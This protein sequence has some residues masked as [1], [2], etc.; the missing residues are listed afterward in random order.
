ML[1]PLALMSDLAWSDWVT[2]LK[3][4]KISMEMV[5]SNMKKSARLCLN[6]LKSV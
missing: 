6:D 5:L 3:T 1:H 4:Y 2:E